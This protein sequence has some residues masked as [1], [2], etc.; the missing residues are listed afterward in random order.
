ML[1]SGFLPE[2][3][4]AGYGICYLSKATMYGVTDNEDED[5]G[6]DKDY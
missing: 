3:P 1:A 4:A 2:Y 6:G 5:G